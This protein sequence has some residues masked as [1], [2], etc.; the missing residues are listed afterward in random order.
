[1]STHRV[2]ADETARRE[3]R[4]RRENVRIAA[5]AARPA[6]QVAQFRQHHADFTHVRFCPALAEVALQ[7]SFNILLVCQNRAAQAAKL[8]KPMRH[9]AR[10]AGR[11]AGF[12]R[13]EQRGN[14]RVGRIGRHDGAEDVLQGEA[15]QQRVLR[16]NPCDGGNIPM[17][18]RREGQSVPRM[19]HEVAHPCGQRSRAVRI[20][21]AQP[22][23]DCH[24]GQ[25]L[26][27]RTFGLRNH[28]RKQQRERL[29]RRKLLHCRQG[30][31][32]REQHRIMRHGEGFRGIQRRGVQRA[33][34]RQIGGEAFAF[35]H[36]SIVADGNQ[37]S[38][39]RTKGVFCL[40]TLFAR[41]KAAHARADGVCNCPNPCVEQRFARLER[42]HRVI[43][44]HIAAGMRPKRKAA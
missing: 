12:L 42:Q 28:R 40:L 44:Q 34:A 7:G 32:Q 14:I 15:V 5:V 8:V 27:P 36:G 22:R 38:G 23:A 31:Q 21:A 29:V 4:Q 33:A 11:K 3:L 26:S 10:Y 35:R 16:G 13:G 25:R 20:H 17:I 19:E 2:M 30:I 24:V 18:Q 9:G 39:Q 6:E 1:M 41:Q 37:L 43:H